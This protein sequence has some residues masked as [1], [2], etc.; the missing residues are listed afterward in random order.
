G[1]VGSGPHGRIVKRDVEAAL[2]EPRPQP[3]QEAPQQSREIATGREARDEAPTQ[4]RRKSL[5]QYGIRP[6][7]YDL[8]PLDMMRKTIAKR[9]TESFR[10]VPH[11]PLTID[12]EI[13][14]LLK[15]R[16]EINNRFREQGVKISVNDMCIKA[17]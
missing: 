4:E 14:A 5:E 12:L 6:G 11:F 3:R 9:M 7:T 2:K 13:D 15:A 8:V 1:L 16:S 10:D 17:A